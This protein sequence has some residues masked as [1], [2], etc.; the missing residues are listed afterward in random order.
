[1]LGNKWNRN[2][3][4]RAHIYSIRNG[5]SREQQDRHHSCRYSGNQ[6]VPRVILTASS[7]KYVSG[8]YKYDC[9]LAMC[10]INIF[11]ISTVWRVLKGG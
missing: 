9:R 2:Q 5:W 8:F 11:Y 7:C 10:S 4:Q 6:P 3:S 1:M